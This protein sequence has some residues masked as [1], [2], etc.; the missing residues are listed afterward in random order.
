MLTYKGLGYSPAF[1]A[2]MDRVIDRIG[3]G[4]PVTVVSGPD[5]ICGGLTAACRAA[6]GHDCAKSDTL[7]LDLLAQRQ[8]S[9]LLGRDLHGPVSHTEIS[10]LRTAFHA[11]EIRAGCAGCPWHQTCDQIADSGFK[12]VRL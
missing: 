10:R 5:D 6:S 3:Q 8:V 4:A 12:G 11:G 1:V 9:D 2:N 7:A